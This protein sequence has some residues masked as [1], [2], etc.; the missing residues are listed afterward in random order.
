MNGKALEAAKDNHL[1]PHQDGREAIGMIDLDP[2]VE[3]KARTRGKETKERRLLS[4]VAQSE[5]NSEFD[6]LGNASD[7]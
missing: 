2:T 7:E 6:C 4:V 1:R 3:G 5:P